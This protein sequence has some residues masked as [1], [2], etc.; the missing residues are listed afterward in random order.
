MMCMQ[1]KL[2]E[3]GVGNEEDKKN[4][5]S[6]IDSTRVILVRHGQSTY[7]AQKRYQGSC[8]DSVLT[9]KGRSDAYQ[10]GVALKG[11]ELDA[12]YIS[13]L[14][15]V[16]ETTF[17]ILEGME[18]EEQKRIF[19][20]SYLKEIDM[21]TWQGL[22]YKYVQEHFAADYR[23]W[24]ERP[25]EFQMAEPQPEKHLKTTGVAVATCVQQCYPVLDLYDRTHQ[26]W[27]EILPRHV[28]KTILIVSHSG[29]IRALISTAI[30][31]K[32]EKYHV[33]QQSNC[34]ISILNFPTP[35][36]QQGR[37]E[38]MNITTHLSEVIPKLKN[39]KQGL[40]LLVVPATGT[41]PHLIHQLAERF[42]TIPIDFS[43]SSDLDS[44]QQN[45][46]Q[47]LKY[48]P[49]TVQLQVLRQDFLAIW[50]QNLLSKRAVVP[51]NDIDLTRPTTGL[52]VASP[53]IIENMLVHI[54]DT[55]PQCLQVIPDTLSVVYYPLKS[56]FPVLQAMN[57]T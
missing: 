43:L 33:L 27:Q 20:S 37:L 18:V 21:P 3:K 10:T 46:E 4:P 30:A 15:R 38:A 17:E 50:Q 49:K 11:I 26:F 56:S 29:T 14:R 1:L 44:S 36:E 48:H 13:P 7:N 35:G 42:Q 31:M 34:G 23:C 39:G 22:T 12:I 25:H 45:A 19:T 8:D 40:R 41:A 5:Q 6:K 53:S 51:S 16:K 9:E 24:K 57:I 2:D 52:V 54:L 55:S 47:L 28:G 32:C